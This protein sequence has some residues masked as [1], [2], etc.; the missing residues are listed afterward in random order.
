MWAPSITRCWRSLNSGVA[1]SLNAVA[2]AAMT[3]ISGPPCWP[4]NTAVLIFFA[5]SASSVRM[6]PERGPPIVLWTVEDTTCA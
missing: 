1:A 6:N 3:C 4:G 5:M 2:F